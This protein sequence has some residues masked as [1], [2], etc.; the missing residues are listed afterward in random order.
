MG[1]VRQEEGESRDGLYGNSGG[2]LPFDDTVREAMYVPVN[3]KRHDA[4]IPRSGVRHLIYLIIS[5]A[6]ESTRAT[7]PPGARSIKMRPYSLG[8]SPSFH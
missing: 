6:R 3:G 4:S 2:L 1:Q 5:S 8:P 7:C